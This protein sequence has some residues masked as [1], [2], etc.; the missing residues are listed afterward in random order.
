M[1]ATTKLFHA[2]TFVVSAGSGSKVITPGLA[3]KGAPLYPDEVT[4]CWRGDPGAN[5][6]YWYQINYDR[7]VTVFWAGVGSEIRM[8][9]NIFRHHSI[10]ELDY[11]PPE[12]LPEG[13]YI[14]ADF[15]MDEARDGS[16]IGEGEFGFNLIDSGTSDLEPG[17][18]QEVL[19]LPALND[20]VHGD[21]PAQLQTLLAANPWTFEAWVSFDAFP[22]GVVSTGFGF[23]S[24]VDAPELALVLTDSGDVTASFRYR[25]GAS[26]FVSTDIGVVSPSDYYHLALVVTPG[27]TVDAQLYLNGELKASITDGDPLHTTVPGTSMF[28]PLFVRDGSEVSVP[29]TPPNV[30]VDDIRIY[31]GAKTADK[32]LADYQRGLKQR[33]V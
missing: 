18:T 10:Q 27:T 24:A 31:Y 22:S 7:T 5:G 6:R 4:L 16:I 2:E 13:M 12:T 3:I 8:R 15:E 1:T 14:A 23:G 28:L 29:G 26:D 32:I 30:R 17:F 9:V 20:A 11:V 25:S 19:K 33:T 21:V